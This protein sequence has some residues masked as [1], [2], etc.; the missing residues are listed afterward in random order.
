MSLTIVPIL[1]QAFSVIMGARSEAMLRA[2]GTGYYLDS[3]TSGQVALSLNLRRTT[4]TLMYGPTITEAAIGSR[5]Y[6][7]YV[8]HAAGLVSTLRLTPRTTM[9]WSEYA[10]YGQQ[11]FSVLAV[12]TP[13]PTITSG[14]STSPGNGQVGSTTNAPGQGSNPQNGPMVLAIPE[15]RTIRFGSSTTGLGLQYALAPTWSAGAS[16]GYAL[17]G[18]LDSNV[19]SVFPRRQSYLAGLQLSHVLTRRDSILVSTSGNYILMEPNA[20][21]ELVSIRTTWSHILSRNATM[22]LFGT[23]NYARSN[24]LLGDRESVVL[25][26]VGGTFTAFTAVRP[27]PSHLTVFVSGSMA[28]MVDYQY[29]GISNSIAG[30]VGVAWTRDRWSLQL[31]G[32]FWHMIGSFGETSAVTTYGL[33][34]TFAY[35]LDRRHHWNLLIGSRQ[36]MQ[37][38]SSGQQMPTIWASFVGVSYTSGAINL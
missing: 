32:N 23:V 4:W 25:P 16:A 37:S 24:D 14:T 17:M 9:T 22:S 7:Q 18:E 3:T 6:Y 36:A 28:P 31:A 19:P 27:R 26:G 8:N 5:Y 13:A 34:E 15:N 12:N 21:S 10:T 33:A 35:A 29:G 30:A 20:K 2:D 11:N 38:F 1:A